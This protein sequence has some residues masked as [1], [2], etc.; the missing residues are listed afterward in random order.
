MT[1]VYT[2]KEQMPRKFYVC[3]F[4]LDAGGNYDPDNGTPQYVVAYKRKGA[5]RWEAINVSEDFDTAQ[6]RMYEL[7]MRE[8]YY[9]VDDAYSEG[10][11]KGHF[12]RNSNDREDILC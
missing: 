4:P 3:Q 1:Q 9:A 5:W 7:Q 12:D 2:M 8:F 11:K 10:C 6:R